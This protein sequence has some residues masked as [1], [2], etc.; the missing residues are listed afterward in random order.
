M[1]N[2]VDSARISMWIVLILSILL[3]SLD[4]IEIIYSIDNLKI[5]AKKMEK[6]VYETALKYSF[7]HKWSLPYLLA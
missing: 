6:S 7:S 3:I 2:E 1:E 5:V 4:T